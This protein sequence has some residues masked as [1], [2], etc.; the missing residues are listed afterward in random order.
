MHTQTI[1]FSERQ[2][3]AVF[4]N[5]RSHLAQALSELGLK[6]CYPAIVLIG[7]EMDGQPAAVTQRA[8]EAVVRTA[9][10]MQAVLICRGTDT[11][12]MAQI[13]QIRWRHGYKFPL[14]GIMP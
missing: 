11:G 14:I 1:V 10:D 3:P 13:G 8:L 9:A 4:P 7:G 5:E 2:T 12:I 6:D